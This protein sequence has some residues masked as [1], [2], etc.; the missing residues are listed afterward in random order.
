MN[1]K[2]IEINDNDTAILLIIIGSSFAILW[3]ILGHA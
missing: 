3:F 1:T 2:I